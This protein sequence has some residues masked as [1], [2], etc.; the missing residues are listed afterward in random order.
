MKSISLKSLLLLFLAA[1]IT[2]SCKEKE[3]PEP[4]NKLSIEGEWNLEEINFLSDELNW[5]ANVPF[6]SGTSVKYG[7]Y[8]YTEVMGY[9]FSTIEVDQGFRADVIQS[10]YPAG[11]QVLWY[12]NYTNE[13]ESF[14]LTQSNL[15]FP[16]YDF[17]IKD[18]KNL[19]VSG[20]QISFEAQIAS[21][22]SGGG[23]NDVEYY[24]A[25]LKLVK[26]EA[27]TGTRVSIQ[28]KSFMIPAGQ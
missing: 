3:E 1:A 10:F 27:T 15:Q 28:G 20:N 6:N 14:V 25:E 21:R 5:N 11:E 23:F 2:L 4:D 24:D 17:G 26:G 13:Q 7:P 22:L 12:W 19:V 18:I 9:N 16:P 8:M